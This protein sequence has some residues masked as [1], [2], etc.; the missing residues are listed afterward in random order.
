MSGNLNRFLG[1]SLGRTILKLLVISFIVGVI[2]AAMNWYPIDVFYTVRDFIVRI[3]EQGFAAIGRV[4]EYLV[5]GAAVV[6][7]VFILLRLLNYRRG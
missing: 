7:P 3:W 6:I 4:G 2:M 1:D 5:L